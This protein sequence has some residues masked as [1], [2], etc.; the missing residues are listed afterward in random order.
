MQ[1]ILTNNVFVYD[2]TRL[3]ILK[4]NSQ[5]LAPNY[6]RLLLAP[7]LVYSS[8]PIFNLHN[9]LSHRSPL[10][11]NPKFPKPYEGHR[12][13]VHD[14]ARVGMVHIEH[15]SFTAQQVLTK[16]LWLQIHDLSHYVSYD[17]LFSV[18]LHRHCLD[19]TGSSSI[20]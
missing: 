16:Q 19:E 13:L 12:P 14:R 3:E 18:K 10:S 4:Y 20:Y 17:C 1:L 7:V 5:T 6:N 15:W 2:F 8:S 11:Q 9:S